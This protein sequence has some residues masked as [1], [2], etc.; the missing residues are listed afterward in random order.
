MKKIKIADGKTAEIFIDSAKDRN[1]SIEVGKRCNVNV[2]VIGGGATK[3][4]PTLLTGSDLVWRLKVDLAGKKTALNIHSLIIGSN[5]KQSKNEIEI[6]HL[7]RETSSAFTGY[8]LLQN[9]DAH[10]WGVTTIIEKIAKKSSAS[11]KIN[12][13]LLGENGIVK[14]RPALLIRNNDVVCSHA[15]ATGHLD[16][17]Q[18]F[19]S[20]ARGLTIA[21]SKSLLARGFVEPFLRKLPEQSKQ[22]LGEKIDNLLQKTNA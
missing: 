17:E 6:K 20:R 18:L 1:V 5:G 2:L 13:L 12:N 8:A 3:Q 14:N 19:Y 10:T 21:Q 9:G 11:Q 7:A 22:E 4:G 15:V 16:E